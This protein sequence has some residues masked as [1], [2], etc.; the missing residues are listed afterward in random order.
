MPPGGSRLKQYNPQRYF[1]CWLEALKHILVL[2]LWILKLTESWFSATLCFSCRAN[3]LGFY[4]LNSYFIYVM[5]LFIRNPICWKV[6]KLLPLRWSSVC[7]TKG[8]QPTHW[9]T[10][11]QNKKMW[12]NLSSPIMQ[13]RRW[14]ELCADLPNTVISGSFLMRPSDGWGLSHT[15]VECRRNSPMEISVTWVTHTRD[16]RRFEKSAAAEWERNDKTR[17]LM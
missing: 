1:R 16:T 13:Q 12:E 10:K 8:S 7:S 15:T 5:K 6:L 14:H 3:T 2:Q 17:R 11:T 9:S 4:W